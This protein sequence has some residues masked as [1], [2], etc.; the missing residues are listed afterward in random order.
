MK[1]E[2]A[3]RLGHL[4]ALLQANI[5]AIPTKFGWTTLLYFTYWFLR[6]IMDEPLYCWIL[7][8]VVYFSLY[9]RRNTERR[10][11]FGAFVEAFFELLLYQQT[12]SI[13]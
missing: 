4:I 11:V 6:P 5:A 12:Y 3:N 13:L 10:K 8:G 2:A 1:R 9:R 7:K